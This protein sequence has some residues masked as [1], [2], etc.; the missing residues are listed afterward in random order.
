MRRNRS[1]SAFWSNGT[2]ENCTFTKNTVYG[3]GGG[4]FIAG[5]SVV[6]KNCIIWDNFAST[7]GYNLTYSSGVTPSVTYTDATELSSATGN[8]FNADPK[9][10]DADS[11][12]FTP[13]DNSPLAG[14]GCVEAW[15]TD[16]LDL[17]GNARLW[18]DGTVTPGALEAQGRYTGVIADF[19]VDGSSQDRAPFTA[20]FRADASGGTGP[21]SY[22]WTFG[23]GSACVTTQTAEVT[24]VYTGSG[25]YDVSLIVK[26]AEGEEV[27]VPV[28]S[29]CITAVGEVCYVSETGSATKPY[30]TWEKAT[31]SIE[32]AIALAPSIVLVTNGTYQLTVANGME[33]TKAMTVKSVEGPDNTFVIAPVNTSYTRHVVTMSHADA[34]VEGF[35]F[36]QTYHTSFVISAGRLA[37]C[38]STNI[39]E[40]V[41]CVYADISGGT[42]SGCRFDFNGSRPC[43]ENIRD[44]AAGLSLSGSAVVDR[45]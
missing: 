41:K 32:D 45:C 10:V 20:T 6:V 9:F 2:I 27:A 44:N 26:P 15:M 4:L 43:D 25:S 16:A 5:S 34:S 30:D 36:L 18:T 13:A 38:I 8:N 29:G 3:W 39:K 35:N 7:D 23:D 12:N 22:I 28:K 1:E 21:Y 19:S 17:A 42:V 24:H 31:S 37:N 14:S 40:I 33:L 11:G